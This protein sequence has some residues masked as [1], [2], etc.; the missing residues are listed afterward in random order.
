MPGIKV[1]AQAI[2]RFYYI[3]LGFNAKTIIKPLQD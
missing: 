1:L 2:E 3:K